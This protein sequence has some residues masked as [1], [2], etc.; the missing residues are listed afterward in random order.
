MRRRSTSDINGTPIS[1]THDEVEKLRQRVADLD[2]RLVSERL[3]KKAAIHEMRLLTASIPW[4]AVALYRQFMRLVPLSLLRGPAFRPDRLTGKHGVGSKG[5]SSRDL[6]RDRYKI[7]IITD[8]DYWAFA[9][10][11]R[12]VKRV[13]ANEVDVHIINFPDFDN[14][15][16]FLLALE[17]YDLVHFMPR[18]ILLHLA[19]SSP[20]KR[21]KAVRYSVDKS[22]QTLQRRTAVTTAVCEHACSDKAGIAKYK[23]LFS[24][25]DG[26]SVCSPKLQEIYSRIEACPPPA[27][28]LRDGVDLNFFV[29]HNLER[30]S[31]AETRPLVVGWAGNSLWQ[32]KA[33]GTDFKGLHTI[34]RPAL[35]ML[36]RD[37]IEMVENFADRHIMLRSYT[38]MPEYYRSIDVLVC[39]SSIEGTPNPV[40]EAM[41]CGVPIVSTDVGIVSETLGPLQS[42][43]ILRERSVEAMAATLRRLRNSRGLLPRLSSENLESIRPCN[44]EVRAQAFLPLFRAAIERRRAAINGASSF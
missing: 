27:A 11:A 37:G 36:A 5:D 7:A 1:D 33:S 19:D 42:E 43:F 29:P 28:I 15:L 26:Y 10:T 41:A 3:A 22:L 31:D 18:W 40:L 8:C 20:Q 39:A 17:G 2:S 24:S 34:L 23:K 12:Q 25:I 16:Q 4:R 9:N 32:S 38:D 30:F 13:L 21:D 6:G 35:E 14:E 44:W